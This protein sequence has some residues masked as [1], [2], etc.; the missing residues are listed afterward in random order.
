LTDPARRYRSST[1]N[2]NLSSRVEDRTRPDRVCG[3]DRI[4]KVFELRQESILGI[5]DSDSALWPRTTR[6]KGRKDPGVW[7]LHRPRNSG[8]VNRAEGP[9][10]N[11]PAR[12]GGGLEEFDPRSEGPALRLC[13]TFGAHGCETR[14]PG[15]YGRGYALSALRAWAFGPG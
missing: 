10:V 6:G 1:M 12:E 14:F 13:R 4:K 15:P 3:C 2:E 5:R 11:S 9:A 8:A 7:T